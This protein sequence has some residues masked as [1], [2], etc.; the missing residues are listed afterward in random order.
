[1][2]SPLQE[3][4]PAPLGATPPVPDDI[5]AIGSKEKIPKAWTDP[6]DCTRFF[7]LACSPASREQWSTSLSRSSGSW[8]TLLPVPSHLARRYRLADG[9]SRR[10]WRRRVSSPLTAAGPRGIFTLFPCS[11]VTTGSTIGACDKTCQAQSCLGFYTDFLAEAPDACEHSAGYGTI[12]VP[13]WISFSEKEYD[14]G[15]YV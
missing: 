4:S 10:Q 14:R 15:A 11:E 12:R 5:F 6:E 9:L 3:A 8:F 7:I 13:T 2:R 1:M